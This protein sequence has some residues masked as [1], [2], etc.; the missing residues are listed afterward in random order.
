MVRLAAFLIALTTPAAAE[1]PRVVTDILPVHSLVAR[2][3]E[4]IGAPE[5][6]L[7][8]GASPHGYAMRPSEAKLLEQ[9][10]IVVW[11]GPGLTPWM[12]APIETIASNATAVTLLD[13]EG[14]K[15][16]A[17]HTD[18]DHDHGDTD[19]HAWLDPRNA[20]VW[21]AHIAEFLADQDPENAAAYR[22]NA[23]TAETEIAE[24]EKAMR[25]ALDPLAGIPF[26]VYHDAYGYVESRFGIAPNFALLSSE[27][28]KPSPRRIA[29]LRD[30][31]EK[32]GI[33]MIVT[34]PQFD[35]RLAETV[36]AGMD[37]Q[38]CSVD[39]LSADIPAGP[40]HYWLSMQ[41]FA[42]I[43]GSCAVSSSGVE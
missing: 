36:F 38:R 16:L 12:A 22:A 9:A 2:V 6:I 1:V 5:L 28:D 21:L 29:E 27:A 30:R 17:A 34:E 40:R 39:I 32:D 35:T 20:G 11:I 19:P 4:G 37:V 18:D 15:T 33:R 13:L 43:L 24:L 14:T 25:T 31:A 42:E 3:M 10:D 41:S 8:P 23:E 26:A 7:P